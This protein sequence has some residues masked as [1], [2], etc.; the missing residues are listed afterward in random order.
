[1][2]RLV[3]AS[4]AANALIGLVQKQGSREPGQGWIWLPS[5]DPLTS[6]VAWSKGNPSN[7]GGTEHFGEVNSGELNDINAQHERH[8]LCECLLF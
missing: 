8:A 3:Q 4:G 5:G 2:A 6:N 7:S 1:M